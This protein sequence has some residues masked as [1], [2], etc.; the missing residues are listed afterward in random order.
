[1]NS[2]DSNKIVIAAQSSDPEDYTAHLRPLIDFLAA[3]GNPP[4]HED[5]FYGQG[6]SPPCFFLS[7]SIDFDRLRAHFIFP[8][9]I[10]LEEKSGRIWDED[11][12]LEITAG[13]GV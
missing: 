3:S 6:Q 2:E 5:R 11:N 10:H 7:R 12:A 9:S 8:P 4:R 1:M 13:L